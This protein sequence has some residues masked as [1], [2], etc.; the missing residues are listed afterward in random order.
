MVIGFNKSKV[1]LMLGILLFDVK[2][3]LAVVLFTKLVISPSKIQF[4]EV[5]NCQSEV[6]FNLTKP[7]ILA[8]SSELI[9]INKLGVLE[10][11]AYS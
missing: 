6:S 3:S 2:N 10:Y 8:T 9:F 4:L 5:S 1:C 11:L 7:N